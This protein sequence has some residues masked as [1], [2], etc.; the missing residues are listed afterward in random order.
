MESLPLEQARQANH[1]RGL[2]RTTQGEVADADH[3]PAQ[4]LCGPPV[5][6]RV[7]GPN[8]RPVH[9][10]QRGQQKWAHGVGNKP[11]R[12]VMARPVAPDS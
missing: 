10:L 8:Q 12:A 11:S 9:Q 1:E 6:A 4:P 2:A 3:R 7:P 5:K